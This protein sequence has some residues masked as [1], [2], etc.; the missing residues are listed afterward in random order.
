MSK[1]GDAFRIVKKHKDKLNKVEQAE[2][3]IDILNTN[4]YFEL[5]SLDDYQTILSYSEVNVKEY[6]EYQK[7]K[8]ILNCDDIFLELY[9]GVENEL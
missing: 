5:N 4:D 2:L 1:I 9:E 6:Y 3:M 7:S 8:D